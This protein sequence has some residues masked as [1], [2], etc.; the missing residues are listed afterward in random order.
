[1]NDCFFLGTMAGF[2]GDGMP[3][4]P[5]LLPFYSLFSK[6]DTI[7]FAN[8]D[9]LSAD[10]YNTFVDLLVQFND[11]NLLGLFLKESE[12]SLASEVFVTHI[13]R[14]ICNDWRGRTLA[15]DL[16]NALFHTNVKKSY[17]VFCHL[18]ENSAE[19]ADFGMMDELL[20]LDRARVFCDLAGDDLFGGANGNFVSKT[21]LAARFSNKEP[22]SDAFKIFMPVVMTYFKLHSLVNKN[23]LKQLNSCV[24]SNFVQGQKTLAQLDRLVLE[25]QGNTDEI[26]FFL[27]QL[28][29]YIHEDQKQNP[30]KYQHPI[31]TL[32]QNYTRA[33]K[34]QNDKKFLED[35]LKISPNQ[36]TSTQKTK[37]T[38]ITKTKTTKI[39]ERIL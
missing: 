11:Q 35:N 10:N 38:K 18:M 39:K 30:Y 34:A 37:T 2:E 22:T 19:K 15:N 8:V 20:T 33:K 21:V 29:L 4:N 13:L 3:K 17:E 14:S 12:R 27:D 25:N 16:V 31:E 32:L 26:M 23:Q 28:A 6:K 1:M 9:E 36:K 7:S 24:F 5:Q